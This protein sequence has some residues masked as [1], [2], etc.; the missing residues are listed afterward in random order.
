MEKIKKIT[1]T[2]K[3]KKAPSFFVRKYFTNDINEYNNLDK[4]PILFVRNL[5]KRYP[6]KKAP[7]INNLN[8][9]VYPGEFHAFIGGNGAGKTT[10]IKSLIGAYSNFNGTILIDGHKNNT[11]EAKKAIGYIPETARFPDNFS[12]FEYIK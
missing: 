1:N 9:N 2:K 3:P 4:K 10:T 12:A 11:K 5:T 8:F 7:A 6:L